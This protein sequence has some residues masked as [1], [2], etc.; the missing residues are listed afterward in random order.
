MIAPA[1]STRTR[2]CF[3]ICAATRAGYVGKT[4]REGPVRWN[5]MR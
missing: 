2:A 5:V 3:S 1:T 4:H